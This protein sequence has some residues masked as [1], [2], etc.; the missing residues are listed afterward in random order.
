MATRKPTW[1]NKFYPSDA[2]Q[3]R[4]MWEGFFE[5]CTAPII[6]G[7]IRAVQVPHAGWIYSGKA[8][9]QAY[10]QLKNRNIRTVVM[11]GPQ[12]HVMAR[13][14]QV[15]PQGVWESPLGDLEVDSELT[16]KFLDF[17]EAF[18]IDIRAHQAEHSLEVQLAPLAMLLPQ[19][20][21]VPLLMAPYQPSHPGI[22]ADALAAIV[23]EAG[24]VIVLVSTDLYHGES[25]KDCKASDERTIELVSRLDARGLEQAL[26]SGEAAACGGD[27]LVGLLRSAGRLG[28]KRA[29]LLAAYN[30]NEVTGERSGYVVGYSAFA[31]TGG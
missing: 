5:G 27:G 21:I 9:A 17:D 15:F 13:S 18:V 4:R 23:G 2:D 20:K 7:T 8:A 19:V 3:A 12:H 16:Q 28:I 30:S 10:N 29:Q 31:F 14:I 6:A 26:A 11:I 25:Y 22:L 24:D 1:G